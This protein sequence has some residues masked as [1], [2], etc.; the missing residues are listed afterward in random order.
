MSSTNVALENTDYDPAWDTVLFDECVLLDEIEAHP[1]LCQDCKMRLVQLIEVAFKHRLKTEPSL[2]I[3]TG[4]HI[5]ALFRLPAAEFQELPARPRL[6]FKTSLTANGE[7]FFA[8]KWIKQMLRPDWYNSLVEDTVFALCSASAPAYESGQAPPDAWTPDQCKLWFTLRGRYTIQD[9]R[10]GRSLADFLHCHLMMLNSALGY[11]GHWAEHEC[12]GR[13][14]PRVPGDAYYPYGGDVKRQTAAVFAS[15]MK[16]ADEQ[17][18]PVVGRLFAERLRQTGQDDAMRCMAGLEQ[19]P[20][21]K[22][23]LE[24]AVNFSSVEKLEEMAEERVAG[25]RRDIAAR[26]E[27]GGGEVTALDFEDLY[28]PIDGSITI[29]Y[30]PS[31]PEVINAF[32]LSLM[33]HLVCDIV[34]WDGEPGHRRAGRWVV[35]ER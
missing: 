5:R 21:F 3:P 14:Y 32:A 7:P 15:A 30:D 29:R 6:W 19:E 9:A 13:C 31:D 8:A 11:P 28:E 34:G 12:G 17:L 18:E 22:A 25:W 33:N 16:Y 26:R 23:R 2:S 27:T 35:R 4:S 24:A 20:Y 1:M 10:L